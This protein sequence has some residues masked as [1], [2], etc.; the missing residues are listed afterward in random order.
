MMEPIAKSE[1]KMSAPP[2]AAES[3]PVVP[4]RRATETEY[5]AY[6]ART[7]HNEVWWYFNGLAPYRGYSR[8][9]A[10]SRGRFWFEVKR[11]FVW[12]VNFFD[13]VEYVAWHPNLS[14]KLLGAQ[15]PVAEQ[16]ANSRVW[17]N[18]IHDLRGYDIQRVDADKRRAVRKGIKNLDLVMLDPGD[19]QVAAAA[20]D[21]WNSHVQ[22][23]GWNTPETPESFA[24]SWREL[25]DWPGTT[26]IG[27]RDRA[28]GQLC[29]WT[30]VRVIDDVAYVDTLASHTERLANRPNDAIVFT[31]VYS[32]AQGGA[33]RAHYSLRSRIASLEA[34]KASMGFE[35]FAFPARLSL[36]FP[37]GLGLQL[38]ANRTYRRLLGDPHWAEESAPAQSQGDARS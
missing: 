23:T 33:R 8:P 16:Q 21:V 37:V 7:R 3:F 18:V 12:P 34:F 15:W 26:V 35:P 4:L 2:P 30:I 27:A 29:S 11:G 10:D 1:K 13:T 20:R 25:R 5:C 9:F 36:R 31:A 17:M 24:A 22:R 38:F 14:L 32:A 6:A 19:A 28:S